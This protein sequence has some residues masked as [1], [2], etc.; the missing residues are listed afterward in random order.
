[1]R[2][3]EGR[4]DQFESQD[5]IITGMEKYDIIDEYRSRQ[6]EMASAGMGQIKEYFTNKGEV[7]QQLPYKTETDQIP[8]EKRKKGGW[9]I[10]IFVILLFIVIIFAAAIGNIVIALG[11]FF[12]GIVV[13][14]LYAVITGNARSSSFYEGQ[15]ST[16][17]RKTALWFVA[18]GLAALVPLF[19]I[20][21]FGMKGSMILMGASLFSMTALFMFVGLIDY[22]TLKVRKY[23]EVVSANCVGY[24]RTVRSSDSSHSSHQGSTQYYL[25]TSPLFEYYYEGQMYKGLYDRPIDDKNGDVELGTTTIRIDPKHPEDIYHG[26]A[27][28]PLKGV[29]IGIL[30]AAVAAFLFYNFFT[31]D[32]ADQAKKEI[33]PLKMISMMRDPESVDLDDFYDGSV[34]GIPSEITDEF[35]KE[36]CIPDSWYVE[37]AKVDY[38]NGPYDGDY[39]VHMLDE[40]FPILH[41]H[42]EA[43]P[44]ELI[45]YRVEEYEQ[46]GEI[47]ISK[48]PFLWLNADEYTYVGEHGAYEN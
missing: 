2:Y 45:F 8:E 39:E 32:Y 15:S 28:T 10:L 48:D 26:N 35:I 43:G 23:T 44:K 41:Q 7:T 3:V 27:V 46:D 11:A 42:Y 30:C 37:E 13:L 4:F 6:M 12:G 33:T 14:A 36:I 18:F 21:K 5:K 17:T 19:F 20:P 34:P 38:V 1:M 40:A 22:L 31:T 16:G 25:T 47:K 9:G 29:G 24:V